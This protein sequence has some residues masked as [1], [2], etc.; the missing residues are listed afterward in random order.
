MVL[1]KGSRCQNQNGLT[2][3]L[4][5]TEEKE[6]QSRNI[7]LR[8]TAEDRS[9]LPVPSLLGPQSRVLEAG[10]CPACAH[11]WGQRKA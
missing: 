1:K 8:G 9:S 7:M 4:I 2:S 6:T 5:L 11:G 3:A 10:L